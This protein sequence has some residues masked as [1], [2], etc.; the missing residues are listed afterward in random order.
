MPEKNTILFD[1]D[2]TLTDPALGITKSVAYAL[3][4]FGIHTGDPKEL[5]KFIGPPLKDSFMEYYGFSEEKALAG[6]EKY[7]EYFRETGIFEN[8][9]YPGI[10]EMLEK[11]K[12]KGMK[13]I[14][15]T[16]KPKVF[17][18]IILEHFDIMKYFDLVCGCELDGTRGKKSEVIRYALDTSG[19]RELDRAVMVGDR[20]HDVLGAREA[21]IGC[22]GVLFG[23]GGYEELHAAG[24]DVIVG[25]VEELG[26]LLLGGFRK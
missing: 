13:V 19:V 24:A 14:L 6:V 22:I 18:D 15:A 4:S 20:M 12:A 9:L 10:K 2:G 23:Y 11:L 17:A 5:C 25:S 8:K 16:S 1:L 26:E 3:E 7:R 21:G